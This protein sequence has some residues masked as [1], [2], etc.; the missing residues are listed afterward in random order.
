MRS[1]FRSRP[2]RA[3]PS[4]RNSFQARSD[5]NRPAPGRGDALDAGRARTGDARRCMRNEGF[6]A[7]WKIT[8][9]CKYCERAK[10]AWAEVRAGLTREPQTNL[11]AAIGG[12][13]QAPLFYRNAR[14]R[15]ALVANWIDKSRSMQPMTAAFIAPGG[16]D[17]HQSRP[18]HAS[19]SLSQDGE[20]NAPRLWVR[21]SQ[22]RSKT[23]CLPR[24]IAPAANGQPV[25]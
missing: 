17:F 4:L 2:T 5:I 10:I 8:L 3:A 25:S 11:E 23:S 15:R 14:D 1:W 22:W 18:N 13:F 24:F 12:H 6:G 16:A 20:Q 19:Y 21:P 9:H 7:R